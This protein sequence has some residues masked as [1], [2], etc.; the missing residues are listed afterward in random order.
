M[1]NKNRVIHFIGIGGIGMSGIAEV[2]HN[3]GYIVKGSDLKE[4]HITKH[5]EEI[6]IKVFIGHRKENVENADVIVYSNAIPE[7]N[8]EII[9]ARKK[10]IPIIPRA[11]MLNEL[12]RIKRGIGISGTHGKTTTTSMTSFILND[13]K[14]DPT[15]IIGGILKNIKSNAKLGKGEFLVYEAC[16][17]FGSIDYFSSGEIV[18]ITNID[19]DHLEYY[20][21]MDNL[22]N[23]FLNF[24]NRIPFYGFAVLN[25]DDKNIRLL[26]PN[27]RKNFYLFGIKNKDVHFYGYD[28]KMDGFITRFKVNFKDKYLGEFTLNLPGIHNV[29]NSLAAIAISYNL[30]VDVETIRRA[31]YNFV[32]AK[33]RFEFIGEVNNIFVVDDYAHH[34]TEIEATIDAANQLKNG[35]IKRVVVIFQPHLFSRTQLHYVNFGLSLMKSDYVILNEIYPAREEPIP[36]VTSALIEDVFKRHDY[37]NYFYA[38]SFDSVIKKSLEIAK[39]GDLFITMGAGDVNTLGPLL[40]QEFKKLVKV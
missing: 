26:V 25:G 10:Q 11:E 23:T 16:E 29:Y 30:G 8:P 15:M 38:K 31:L 37:K 33:R 40:L 13:A 5:L 19:D 28:I 17:A 4:T 12:L 20:K 9:E 1:K 39:E 21:T 24:I 36:G 2:L 32:N 6:G 18:C 27:I 35:K 3:M 7:E 14:Y 22:I 34:P